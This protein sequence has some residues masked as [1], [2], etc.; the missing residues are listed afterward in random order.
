MHWIIKITNTYVYIFP[1]FVW[2]PTSILF[3]FSPHS[4]NLLFYGEKCLQK[5]IY[6]IIFN[7]VF[8]TFFKNNLFKNWKITMSDTLCFFEVMYDEHASVYIFVKFRI[9]YVVCWQCS[10]VPCERM[11]GNAGKC[12]M[13]FSDFDRCERIWELCVDYWPM[14]TNVRNVFWLFLIL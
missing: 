6:C 11:W 9:H 2:A 1:I 5:T 3:H 12:V 10:A 4:L 7:W 14:W 8:Y 13:I